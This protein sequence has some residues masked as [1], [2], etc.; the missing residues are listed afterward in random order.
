MR[1]LLATDISTARR[2]RGERAASGPGRQA[3]TSASWS[4]GIG[5]LVVE[6]STGALRGYVTHSGGSSSV[7]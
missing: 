6:L 7:K 2:P 4:A 3:P 1:V 5:S